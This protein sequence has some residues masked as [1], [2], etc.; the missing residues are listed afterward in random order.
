MRACN[1]GVLSTN[2]ISPKP[3]FSRPAGRTFINDEQPAQGGPP[4]G[5]P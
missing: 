4:F 5:S 1:L 3:F 2:R